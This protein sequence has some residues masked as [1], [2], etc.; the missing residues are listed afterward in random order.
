MS[1]ERS[2]PKG[3]VFLSYARED[4]DAARRIADALRS[5][6]VEVWFDQAEL[7]GGEAWDAKI[8]Q[9][10][11]ECTLFLAVVSANTQERTEGYF[12]REWKLAVERTSDMAAGVAFLVPVVI[13]DTAEGQALAPE[14]FMRVQWTRLPGALPTPDFV[15][16][17]KSLLAGG[18]RR[19]PSLAPMAQNVTAT[20]MRT[21]PPMTALPPL[22][23]KPPLFADA[24]DDELL[25]YGVPPE[26][27]N[28]A[29]QAT[30]DTLLVLADRLP[31][32]AAEALLELA[33]GGKPRVAAP[34][35][36]AT[37][38]FDHPDAQRR[39]RVMT[40]VEE[41]E[42]ALEFPWEKW[43]VF[44]HPEQRQWVERDYKGP[45]RVSGSAGRY[46]PIFLAKTRASCGL[47]TS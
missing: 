23:P 9:Q 10:I 7:R 6:G 39:F 4:A 25:G 19:R 41:L 31:A 18:S 14:E 42:R 8:R 21:R 32:E 35:A 27:L 3:A 16:Q 24:T 46:R 29:R 37:N 28:D 30:E 20:P 5:Q 11:R 45:A 2:A 33:T 47:P 15:A 12:R 40:N 43:T 22:A 38:P 36:M 13:D 1:V 26:W 34:V 17:T 44:L